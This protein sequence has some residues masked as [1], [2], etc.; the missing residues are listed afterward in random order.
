MGMNAKSIL[1]A[2]DIHYSYRG[3]PVLNGV[4]L[5][6]QT[7]EIVSLLGANGA[8]KSTLLR[9]LMGFTAPHK[10]KVLLNGKELRSYPRRQLAQLIAYVPQV[11]VTPF[12]YLVREVAMLGRLSF[13][14]L[15]RAPSKTDDAIVT[16]VLETLEISHLATV[17]YTEISGGERQLTLI[18]RALVQ[19]ARILILDEPM[20]GLDYG[21]QL[22][23][24]K[25]LRGLAEDGY[26]VLKTTHYPEHALLASS[27]AI[28][29]HEG[30]IKEDGLPAEV[31]TASTIQWL[32]GVRVEAHRHGSHT[33]F[34]PA[35][36]NSH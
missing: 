26:A 10:G 32:Y 29:L 23:L 5:S 18:A 6:L 30:L 11:H 36:T 24:L 1:N 12:P 14:G 28:L 33:A 34:F 13:T 25:R 22:H 19:G 31:V 4:N 9:L 35:S 8:G 2:C 27:R 21:H 20:N 15:N 3:H 17:P 7:G 16:N